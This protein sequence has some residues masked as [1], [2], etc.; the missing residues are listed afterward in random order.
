[1]HLGAR[2]SSSRCVEAASSTLSRYRSLTS[3]AT[4]H[5]HCA[6]TLK[7]APRQLCCACA[8]GSPSNLLRANLPA[9]APDLMGAKPSVPNSG[10]AQ[11]PAGLS[12]AAGVPAA[13][14][15]PGTRAP[16]QRT[17][18]RDPRA[19]PSCGEPQAEAIAVG[20]PPPHRASPP[21]GL[22][23]AGLPPSMEVALDSAH[24][25]GSPVDP[26]IDDN[27]IGQ[28]A[29]MAPEEAAALLA[30]VMQKAPSGMREQFDD[31]MMK[32]LS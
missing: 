10:Q 27:V 24:G 6:A 25:Q 12:S 1:L 28:L 26:E 8:Q 23:V 20:P 21:G 16:L 9:S 31:K 30:E 14:V 5:M 19:A 11:L 29:G 15:G 3:S 22:T 2:Q 7:I 13:S 18:R 32:L 4:L 17:V